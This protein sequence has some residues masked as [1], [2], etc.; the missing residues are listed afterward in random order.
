ML[1][2]L[3]SI[4]LSC[5]APS[6]RDAHFDLGQSRDRIA[7]ANAAL[8]AAIDERDLLANENEMRRSAQEH[9]ARTF[10]RSVF[11]NAAKPSLPHALEALSEGLSEAIAA[12][13][14]RT[15]SLAASAP[16]ATI[17][18]YLDDAVEPVIRC[19]RSIAAT[20]RAA[21]PI[22]IIVVTDAPPDSYGRR[23]LSRIAGVR[24]IGRERALNRGIALTLHRHSRRT[25]DRNRGLARRAHRANGTRS[26]CCG[27]VFEDCR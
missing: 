11:G 7:R 16:I 21:V 1:K 20:S 26:C 15:P 22:E 2:L 5:V 25:S 17:V 23:M 9:P 3:M 14:D 18:V 4:I 8:S 6:V 10:V 13:A 19:L 27:G 24:F 12:F